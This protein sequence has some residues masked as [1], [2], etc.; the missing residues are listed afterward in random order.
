[1]VKFGSANWFGDY[2]WEGSGTT[3]RQE[4]RKRKGEQE[5][6]K[7][8]DFLEN[9]GGTALSINRALP[10]FPNLNCEE[11]ACNDVKYYPEKDAD[12]YYARPRSE[13]LNPSESFSLSLSLSY[14]RTCRKML[15]CHFHWQ[16]VTRGSKGERST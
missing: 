15:T 1:M 10:K 4:T 13:S 14:P 6:R 16:S 11:M 12:S 7:K 3:R 5:G 9:G 8:D 2:P